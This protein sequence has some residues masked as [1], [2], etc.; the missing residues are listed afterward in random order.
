M[1]YK[2][3]RDQRHSEG[4]WERSETFKNI[5][6]EKLSFDPDNKLGINENYE[7]GVKIR[8]G[9]KTNNPIFSF[10]DRESFTIYFKQA[11]IPYY[12][13]PITE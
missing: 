9:G 1:K 13:E 10:D 2:C 11:G 4:I 8:V 5:Y 3:T 12:F 6:V 7:L